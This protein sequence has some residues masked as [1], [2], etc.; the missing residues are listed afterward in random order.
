MEEVVWYGFFIVFEWPSRKCPSVVRSATNFIQ[1][2]DR[3]MSV[4]KHR[5]GPAMTEHDDLGHK[6]KHH[7]VDC[8]Q[9]TA[10]EK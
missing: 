1:Y 10:Q 9:K 8:Q 5:C 3:V 2:K 6:A 7:S 4:G